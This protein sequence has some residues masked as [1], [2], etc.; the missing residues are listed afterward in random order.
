[1]SFGFIFGSYGWS[2]QAVGEIEKIINDLSWDVPIKSINI[3]YIPTKDDIKNIK[4]FG[5]EKYRRDYG[6]SNACGDDLVVNKLDETG[7]HVL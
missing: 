4:N 3:N 5:I 7:I 6:N 2:G 1:M